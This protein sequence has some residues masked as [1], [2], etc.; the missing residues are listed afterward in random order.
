MGEQY[1]PTTVIVGATGGVGL[2][3]A[4]RL[5]EHRLILLARDSERLRRLGEEF[6]GSQCVP[7]DFGNLSSIERALDSTDRIDYLVQTTGTI[8]ASRVEDSTREDWH[9]MFDANVLAP[10][11][12]TRAA[13]P[14]VREARGTVIFI[15]SGS[16]R[17]VKA[18]WSG[19][20]ASK[21]ACDA[22]AKAVEL[23]EKDVK[24]LSI[25]AGSIDTPMREKLGER[26]GIDYE[27]GQYLGADDIAACITFA[28]ERGNSADIYEI[29]LR[30][31]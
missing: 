23:E 17:R 30:P 21:S 27:P 3:V 8:V 9:A 5:R 19:Y 6:P 7:V 25:Y 22:L 11:L 15:S 18:G 31:R 28:I 13:L 1:R 26:A 16:A 10:M 4:E 14:K 20:A 2:A 24:V 29:A 12:V